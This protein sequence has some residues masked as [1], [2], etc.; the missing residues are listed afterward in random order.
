MEKAGVRK[1]Q[2]AGTSSIAGAM[3]DPF[4]FMREMFG[5]GRSADRPSFE[6]RETDEGYV[7][8]VNVKLA[9]PAQA[10]A[11]HVKAELDDGELTLVVPKAAALLPQPA[12]APDSPSPQAKKRRTKTDG[13]GSPG[14]TPRR[15]TRT[16]ARRG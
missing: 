5:W 6:V 4:W 7:C 15:G 11:A 2:G 8:K 9:L 16:R 12:P 1:E 10:D 3:W 13:Q 14:R